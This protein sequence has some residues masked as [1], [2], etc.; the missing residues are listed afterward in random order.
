MAAS[1]RPSTPSRF[2][3]QS[4]GFHYEVRGPLLAHT[5]FDQ[6]L[7]AWCR[8][9]DALHHAHSA[10]DDQGRPLH[11]IHR[12]VTPMTIGLGR[13]GKV[14]LCNFGAALSELMGRVPTPRGD[15]P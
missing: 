9:D 8:K 1:P 10:K 4:E 14:K 2:E 13:D 3:F 15:S 6:F 12:A 7:L 11:V 5:D